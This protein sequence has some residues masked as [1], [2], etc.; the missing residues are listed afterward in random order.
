MC[1]MYMDTVK[2]LYNK[3]LQNDM[4]VHKESESQEMI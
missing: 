2:L 3:T 4:E 1:A